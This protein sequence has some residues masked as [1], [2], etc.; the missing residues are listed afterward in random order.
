MEFLDLFII[1]FFSYYIYISG[2]IIGKT[3]SNKS[4]LVF[5]ENLLIGISTITIFINFTYFVLNYSIENSLLVFSIIVFLLF[6]KLNELKIKFFLEKD[7]LIFFIIIF[8]Y[9]LPAV[10]YG[11]QFYI[12]RGN[13]YDSTWYLGNSVIIKNF[14]YSEFLNSS[15]EVLIELISSLDKSLYERPG[16]A[17]FLSIFLLFSKNIFLVNFL[18]KGMLAGLASFSFAF[19][20][21]NFSNNLKKIDK[22]IIIFSITFSFWILY[23]FEID[24]LSQ[25]IF[26]SY[27]S[28]L[29]ICFSKILKRNN[30]SQSILFSLNS[31]A[32]FIF[33]PQQFLILFLV[34]I[35]ILINNFLIVKE[36]TKLKN[37]IFFNIITIILFFLFTVPHWESTY[38]DFTKTFN[39]ATAKVDW[40]GY[41]GSFILGRENLVFNN[42]FINEIKQM[43]INS[44]GFT[45]LLHIIKSHLDKGYYFSLFN[46]LPSIF[47][48]YHFT[49]G[50]SFTFINLIL[51][52]ICLSIVVILIKNFT[53]NMIFIKKNKS[54]SFSQILISCISVFILIF[55]INLIK[56]NFWQLIKLYFFFSFFFIIIFFFEFEKKK[57]ITLKF[58][59]I[60]LLSFLI[61]PIYKYST[62]NHG[63]ARFDSFPSV[64]RPNIKKNFDWKISDKIFSSC[65]KIEFNKNLLKLEKIKKRLLL[66]QLANEKIWN[67]KSFPKKNCFFDLKDKTFRVIY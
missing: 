11:E 30:I 25:L 51:L 58:S 28:Y 29:M 62:Y 47:G 54:E 22:Y 66:I 39:I 4:Q 17:I 12:F 44:S 40:W 5:F 42:E 35:F 10:I 1:F 18:F 49:P 50:K 32:G 3:L 65:A 23:I 52:S 64:I 57:K 14:L 27:F 31:A 26:L 48:Y 63:I 7:I 24:A 59:K 36:V 46:I 33:Y 56:Y 34:L 67:Y 60:I 53:Q 38:G 55:S 9:F 19:L 13:H 8:I 6:I 16:A 2:K 37:I 45:T 20:I 15:N 41:F 43:W 21:E 61:F